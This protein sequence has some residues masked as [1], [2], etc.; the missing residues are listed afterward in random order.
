MDSE[1][2]GSVIGPD[3][4]DTKGY[5]IGVLASD[6]NGGIGPLVFVVF[7]TDRFHKGGGS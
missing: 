7:V 6:S 3:L 2:V 5:T 4:V 1:H